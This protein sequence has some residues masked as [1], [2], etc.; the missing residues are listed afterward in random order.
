M[1]NLGPGNI[2]PSNQDQTEQPRSWRAFLSS[3]WG[4]GDVE[5]A[6]D[7][8]GPETKTLIRRWAR[9]LA[10]KLGS[11]DWYYCTGLLPE[12]VARLTPDHVKHVFKCWSQGE[13][14]ATDAAPFLNNVLDAA[15]RDH[16][17]LSKRLGRL[18][19]LTRSDRDT[20]VYLLAQPDLMA[21]II[22]RNLLS[23]PRL[24]VHHI[25]SLSVYGQRSYC[26]TLVAAIAVMRDVWVETRGESDR[27][28]CF[29]GLDRLTAKLSPDTLLKLIELRTAYLQSSGLDSNSDP[30][31][32]GDRTLEEFNFLGQAYLSSS[33]MELYKLAHA[34]QEAGISA[35]FVEQD[36]PSIRAV[37][38]EIQRLSRMGLGFRVV[39]YEPGEQRETTST[40]TV[41]GSYQSSGQGGPGWYEYETITRTVVEIGPC[42][43]QIVPSE[44]AGPS[45]GTSL[46]RQ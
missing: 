1:S 3:A 25:R 37:C 28:S 33:F 30:L 46:D 18:D 14:H 27:G 16:A 24:R 42:S 6:C 5:R 4:W 36:A 9:G 10:F 7:L 22:D 44:C 21:N 15:S 31:V 19:V 17:E 26:K 39:R 45:T 12:L 38:S 40:E 35:R 41:Q 20:A 32:I 29:E 11:S 34:I 23:E 8:V 13:L 43:L 2:P